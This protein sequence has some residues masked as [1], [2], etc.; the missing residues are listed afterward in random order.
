VKSSRGLSLSRITDIVGDE[1]CLIDL[2]LIGADLA[3]ALVNMTFERE[4]ATRRPF[5]H[6]Q[7]R[8]VDRG[9]QAEI[10]EIEIHAPCGDAL[11][12]P[13]MMNVSGRERADARMTV[14]GVVPPK[15]IMA[16]RPGVLDRAEPLRKC[17][18]IRPSRRSPEGRPSS[19][20]RNG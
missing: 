3:Q 7:Q 4:T 13:P 19:P 17:W 16:M 20:R 6:Q 11:I 14:F 12:R 10:G 18:P 2:P 1:R 9:R 8:V 15:E 5:P